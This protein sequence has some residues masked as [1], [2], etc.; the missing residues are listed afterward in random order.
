M[1]G[2]TGTKYNCH[3]NDNLSTCLGSL[4]AL[5]GCLSMA[6]HQRTLKSIIFVAHGQIMRIRKYCQHDIELFFMQRPF[7][8]AFPYLII[9]QY[10]RNKLQ[11]DKNLYICKEKYIVGLY[12][13]HDIK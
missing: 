1:I 4:V 13:Q 12:R 5:E 7:F 2:L 6:K 9:F 8:S 10:R 11:I 3:A